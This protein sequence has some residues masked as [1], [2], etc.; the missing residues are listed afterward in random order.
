[1]SGDI[2]LNPMSHI[3][4]ITFGHPRFSLRRVGL[5]ELLQFALKANSGFRVQDLRIGVQAFGFRV[6]GQLQKIHV[7]SGATGC[8]WVFVF[9]V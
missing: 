8:V 9:G 5:I 4:Q 3:L 7:A 6:Q 2:S 1:M